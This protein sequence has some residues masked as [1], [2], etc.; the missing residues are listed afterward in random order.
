MSNAEPMEFDRRLDNYA[1]QSGGDWLTSRQARR[2]L[3]K[4]R[5]V[6]GTAASVFIAAPRAKNRPTR[7]RAA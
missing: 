2:S 6:T 4:E 3:H 7:S 5:R 1:R